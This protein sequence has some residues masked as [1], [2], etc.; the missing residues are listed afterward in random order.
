MQPSTK[1]RP[2]GK[3]T[4]AIEAQESIR[5]ATRL[6]ARLVYEVIRRDGNEELSRPVSSLLWSGIAGGL[7][8]SF[9]VVGLALFR[10]HLPD[11]SWRPLVENFGYSFGF[12]LVIL[13]RL[14]LFTENTITTV[15]PLYHSFSLSGLGRVGRLWSV[16]FAANLVG[17]LIAA[18]FMAYSNVLGAPI[19]QTIVEISSHLLDHAW[20][21]TF[22]KAIPAGILIAALV[23]ILP[24][25]NSAFLAITAITYLISLAGFTHVI[26]GSVEV[27]YLAVTGHQSFT[28]IGLGFILPAFCGNVIGGTA[29]FTL[30]AWGQVRKEKLV[31][32]A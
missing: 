3:S 4:K 7:I 27:F 29:I 32:G 8:I 31:K 12:L 17:A 13:G 14:Q 11:T 22:I 26:A 16:V 9:S 19:Q 21:D 15:I 5:E 24:T 20:R 10:H 23:W 18:S 25:T 28:D 1:F 30:M 6:S 2:S